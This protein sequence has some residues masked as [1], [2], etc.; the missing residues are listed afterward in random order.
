M[1]LYQYAV[2][3]HPTEKQKK[4]EGLSS[5]VLVALTTI[6]AQ[7]DKG[8]AIQAARAIPEQYVD[9]LDQVEIAV[10]PF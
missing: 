9:K 6:L 8:A 4:D 1:K 5:K 7:D 3:Y 10:R 2:L